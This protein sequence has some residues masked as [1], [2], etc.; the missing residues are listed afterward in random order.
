MTLWIV[1]LIL[2]ILIAIFYISAYN[3]M[4][5]AKINTEEAWSQITVQ[6][7]RRNDLIPNLVE[8]VKGYAKHEK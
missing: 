8:T 5:K 7:K 3:G 2:V 6:L 4:Q 1:L